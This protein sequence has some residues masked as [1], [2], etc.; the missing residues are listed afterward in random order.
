MRIIPRGP[1]PAVLFL[2]TEGFAASDTSADYDAKIFALAALLSS[3]LTY[4]SVR[5]VD[6]AAV[7]Y[8][9]LLA[10]CGAES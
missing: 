2:D 4:N 8:L 7:E 10:R 1:H 9:E 3:H 5:I 6:T